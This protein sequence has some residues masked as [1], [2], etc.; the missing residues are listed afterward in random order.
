[1]KSKK[2]TSRALLLRGVLF[3]TGL[4]PAFFMLMF[5]FML[6]DLYWAIG[7]G[8]FNIMIILLKITVNKF[9]VINEMPCIHMDAGNYKIHKYLGFSKISICLL[10]V[11]LLVSTIYDNV[12]D[13]L[14]IMMTLYTIIYLFYGYNLVYLL[15]GYGA[16]YIV[17]DN[18]PYL[19]YTK[20]YINLEPIKIYQISKNIY[21]EIQE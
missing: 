9:D 19:V 12:A 10:I 8:I 1:M 20:R 21:I 14:L 2:L 5:L 18:V 3:F 4:L 13:L 15:L 6:I 7:I 17:T 11:L 16:Y